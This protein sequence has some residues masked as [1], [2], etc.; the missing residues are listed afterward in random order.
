MGGGDRRYRGYSS[1]PPR[2]LACNAR[3]RR[4]CAHAGVVARQ[5]VAYTDNHG[6]L[7]CAPYLPS[8]EAK[9]VFTQNAIKNAHGPLVAYA[10]E[11]NQDSPLWYVSN[12]ERRLT[13][14]EY[15]VRLLRER[16]PGARSKG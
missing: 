10:R 4:S 14:I 3:L 13:A 16:L 5:I 7:T 12:S 2:D 11:Q 6:G 15:E 9:G 8:R 1:R